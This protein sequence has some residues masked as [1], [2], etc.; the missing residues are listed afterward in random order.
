MKRLLAATAT[1]SLLAAAA[2]PALAA[3]P[4]NA[5][6]KAPA[7][8]T[9]I[10]PGA[11]A[12][13]SNPDTPVGALNE[14]AS[15]AGS[16]VLDLGGKPEGAVGKLTFTLSW[17]NPASDYDL[18]VGGTNDLATDNPEVRT[19]K[20]KHCKAVPVEVGVYLGLPVDGLTLA[21]KGA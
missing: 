16:F 5:P 17:A 10:K 15:E 1:L 20:A 12:V 6:C 14:T 9:L 3:P 19:F 8:A 4:K 21:V 13:E 7:G 11:K 2:G 18:I